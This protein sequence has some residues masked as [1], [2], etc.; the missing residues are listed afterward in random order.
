[1]DMVL[2]Y[3]MKYKNPSY[4]KGK[5]TF[6]L[7]VV[8]GHCKTTILRYEKSGKGNL[9]K[10]QEHRIIESTFDLN[11]Q[12]NHLYCPICKEQ[13]ANKGSYN[14][15]LTYLVIRGKINSKNLNN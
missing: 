11:T 14:G 10:L 7:E 12:E 1:M 3:A 6:T 5:N 2:C 15:R 4:R 9:I 8:C 13:L